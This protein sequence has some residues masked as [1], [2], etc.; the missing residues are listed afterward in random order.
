MIAMTS[1]FTDSP[2][3]DFLADR[4]LTATPADIGDDRGHLSDMG[5]FASE[6]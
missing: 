5:R 1:G 6:R 3:P 2:I 4:S